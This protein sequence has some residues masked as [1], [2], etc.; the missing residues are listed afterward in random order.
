MNFPLLSQSGRIVL[1]ELTADEPEAIR[2]GDFTSEVNVQNTVYWILYIRQSSPIP[3]PH[4]PTTR[5]CRQLVRHVVR[6]SMGVALCSHCVV[7]L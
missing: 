2:T 1:G 4:S 6:H 3:P 5:F 7:V